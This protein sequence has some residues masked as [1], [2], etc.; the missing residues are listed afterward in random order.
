MKTK[1][2]AKVFTYFLCFSFLLM[3]DGFPGMIAGA[4]ERNIPLGQMVSKGAVKYEA[5]KDVW[6]SVESS[7]FPIFAETKMKTENGTAMITLSNNSQIGIRPD[8][9]F[10]FDQNGRF[11][12]SQGAIEFR[13]PSGSEFD[14]GARNLS[15]L[16]SRMLHVA[17]A[18]P[19]SSE[20]E[21]ETIGSVSIHSNDAVAVKCIQGKLLILNKDRTVLAALSSRESVTIPSIT[22]GGKQ[23]V[24]VAQVGD[25]APAGAEIEGFLG[26]S[27]AAWVGI[28]IGAVAVGLGAWG[29][30]EAVKDD[31][32]DRI[33]VCR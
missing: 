12:L 16:K 24:M 3:M 25:P 20:K 7:H 6:K 4:T 13:I 10:F 17:K 32:H 31:D 23:R 5:R 1:C 15:L 33:P 28:G 8:T 27:T 2:W 11:I 19:V 29:I 18:F 14:L 22:A 9:L 26:L 30:S 21:E